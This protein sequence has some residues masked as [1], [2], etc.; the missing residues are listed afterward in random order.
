MKNTYRISIVASAALILFASCSNVKDSTEY[1]ELSS[2]VSDLQNEAS[3]ANL[4][5]KDNQRKLEMA[6]AN[7]KA[8][9]T[10]L[11]ALQ[12]E[13]ETKRNKVSQMLMDDSVRAKAI[14]Q[15][16]I[17]A[18]RAFGKAFYQ[19]D[20]VSD[21]DTVVNDLISEKVGKS[22]AAWIG[23]SDRPQDDDPPGIKKLISD[24]SKFTDCYR[25]GE[26]DFFKTCKTFDK[27][28]MNKDPSTFKGKC[29][30]GRV[31]VAQFDTNTG[32][33]A[34]QGYL[35]A[36]YS[37]RAQ[38]GVSLDPENHQTQTECSWTSELVE[39]MYINFWGVGLDAY[40]YSTSNGGKQTVPAFKLM[41]WQ[42]A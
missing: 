9:K 30:R 28:F 7:I 1:K 20:M 2:Q 6:T 23:Y 8:A 14:Q 13:R 24:F 15:F 33:C 19:V 10:K 16:S 11:K 32:K 17:P 42:K 38:F 34:F 12:D 4:E 22:N 36:D 21:D 5:L 39:D 18:C 41:R 40:T 35:D 37:F 3:S 31:K 27:R 29:V 26:S 25:D